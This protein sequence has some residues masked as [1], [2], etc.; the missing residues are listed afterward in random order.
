MLSGAPDSPASRRSSVPRTNECRTD[1]AGT[2]AQFGRGQRRQR[3][4]GMSALARGESRRHDVDDFGSRTEPTAEDDAPGIMNV[5]KVVESDHNPVGESCDDACRTLVTLKKSLDDRLGCDASRKTR[6]TAAR[7]IGLP[8]AAAAA[9]TRLAT[10]RHNHVAELTGKT[11][12]TAGHPAPDDC[13]STDAG[14]KCDHKSVVPAARRAETPFRNGRTGCVVVDSDRKVQ[15][16]R[17]GVAQRQLTNAGKVGGDDDLAIAGHQT[18]N[19]DTNRVDLTKGSGEI[20]D[21]LGR[22]TSRV[23]GHLSLFDNP[24]AVDRVVDHDT[25]GLCPPDVHSQTAHK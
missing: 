4:S 19:A 11:V 6:K 2:R 1:G 12:V 8:T 24:T 18:G 10:P 3:A 15:A 23:G 16:R 17:H 5:H 22:I 21:Y 25:Q 13:T 14:T 7:C 9:R 20:D